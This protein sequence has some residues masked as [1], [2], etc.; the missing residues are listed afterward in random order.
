MNFKTFY[1]YVVSISCHFWL[2]R[3]IGQLQPM[4]PLRCE[5]SRYLQNYQYS[6]MFDDDVFT[7]LD[8]L[9]HEIPDHLMY[10]LY[11]DN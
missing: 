11:K 8:P 4:S 3:L 5:L 1:F 9:A 2:Y 7:F 10:E 6:L